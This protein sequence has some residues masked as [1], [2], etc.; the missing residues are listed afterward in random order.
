MLDLV[1]Q[2]DKVCL[3]LLSDIVITL[4][5]GLVLPTLDCGLGMVVA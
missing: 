4:E 5:E 2:A 3:S 1:A